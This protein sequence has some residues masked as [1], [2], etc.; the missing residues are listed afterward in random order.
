VDASALPV[1]IDLELW[2]NSTVRPSGSSVR[3]ELK[4]FIEGIQVRYGRPPLL[5]L[6]YEFY[7]LYLDEGFLEHIWVPDYN[8]P[9][10][11]AL[12]NRWTVWQFTEHGRVDGING[13]VDQNVA[14]QDPRTWG[15][16]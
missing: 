15:L 12:R 11:G 2:G 3:A 10:R 7:D 8:L 14:T 4:T 5:Y 16:K 6:P 1:A 9:P 13:F